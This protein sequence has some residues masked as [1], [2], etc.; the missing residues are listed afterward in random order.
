MTT[1][2][3]RGEPRT[4]RLGAPPWALRDSVCVCMNECSLLSKPTGH[5]EGLGA[6][7]HP[8]G[9]QKEGDRKVAERWRL[10]RWRSS[11]RSRGSRL[12]AP[13][14]DVLYQR[15]GER[16]WILRSS[17]ASTALTAM[18]P[19]VQILPSFLQCLVQGRHCF[20]FK[21]PSITVGSISMGSAN[22]KVKTCRETG[23]S[24]TT[25]KTQLG[26]P[27]PVSGCLGLSSGSS[28]FQL[29]GKVL[30]GRQQVMDGSST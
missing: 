3:P 8:E 14:A 11:L 15:S 26:C 6:F 9:S 22:P 10:G 1:P 29:P 19:F 12:V 23:V 18:A 7:L 16:T 20:K 13:R 21:Q 27:H 24:D 2:P 28:Q 30:P 17:K 25:V 5:Y 4:W